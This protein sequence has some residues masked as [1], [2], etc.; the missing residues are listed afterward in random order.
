MNLR[1]QPWSEPVPGAWKSFLKSMALLTVAFL[2]A[3][4]SARA[5]RQG[6][7]TAAVAGAVAALAIVFWVGA[8]FVPRLAR[9]VDWS[10]LPWISQYRVTK[11]GAIF[12]GALVVVVSAAV[13]TSNN[14]LYMVL[15][16]LLALL[17]MS[18][19]LSVLNLRFLAADVS[20]P[21]RT[22]VS[23]PASMS[24]RIHNAKRTMPSFS[25]TAM[26]PGTAVY[27]G[28]V[29]PQDDVTV[30]TRIAFPRR[31]RHVFDT[32]T[33]VSRFPFGFI[34]R[35]REYRIHAESICYPAILEF[36]RV[37][38]SGTDVYAVRPRFDKGLGCDLYTIRNY[39]P[40]DSARHVHW[41][42]SAKTGS[43]KTREFAAEDASHLVLQFDRFCARGD[44][45]R[46]EELVSHAASLAF[47][48][49]RSGKPVGL[50]S[51]EWESPIGD[52]EAVL[53]SILTYLALVEASAGEANNCAAPEGGIR[54]SLR[55]PGA[56]HGPG[57]RQ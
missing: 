4:Q 2:A 55:G 27:A 22:F 18:G 32:L 13:N 24:L 11:D 35:T 26:L 29:K 56:G 17:S 38:L 40:S 36:E 16:A 1:A 53:D 5:T 52:S 45:A 42:A 25:L 54:L 57:E 49:I 41:K 43:L 30:R 19:I 8:R 23:E 33:L 7:L 3:L 15:S 34:S 47:H 51:D 46:F 10:W 21:E 9:A 31:G 48:L 39:V 14:L 28:V 12:I 44:E 50:I 6:Q 20:L 37:D